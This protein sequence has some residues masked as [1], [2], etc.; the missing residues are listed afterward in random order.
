MT[1]HFDSSVYELE[2]SK[3]SEV[4]VLCH[5]EVSFLSH[6]N[7]GDNFKLEVSLLSLLQT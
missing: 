6:R 1:D 4:D 5:G 7:C 2:A 3:S